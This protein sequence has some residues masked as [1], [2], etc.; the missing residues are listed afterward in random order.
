MAAN[1]LTTVLT[2][3]RAVTCPSNATQSLLQQ[4]LQAS[5]PLRFHPGRSAHLME[6]HVVEVD[7]LLELQELVANGFSLLQSKQK[8][9]CIRGNRVEMRRS[10]DA[11]L[12]RRVRASC[13]DSWPTALVSCNQASAGPRSHGWKQAGRVLANAGRNTGR[14]CRLCHRPT[15]G[16]LPRSAHYRLSSSPGHTSWLPAPSQQRSCCSNSSGVNQLSGP[17]PTAGCAGLDRHQPSARCPAGRNS[18]GPSWKL[19]THA[20]CRV[21]QRCHWRRRHCAMQACADDTAGAALVTGN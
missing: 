3:A 11:V 2:G 7:V 14:S 4:S 17:P 1:T 15:Q 8:G 18:E 21:Q 10:V 20:S 6:A 9:G 12:D 16:S 5:Q 13:R 19:S